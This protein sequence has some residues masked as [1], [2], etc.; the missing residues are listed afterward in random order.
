M[1]NILTVFS[2]PIV[3]T[4][5]EKNT[6]DLKK[7]TIF[8][9]NDYQEY[10]DKSN[11]RVL[12]KYPNVK[13]IL[14]EEYK[15]FAREKL[16]YTEEFNIS[17]SWITQIETGGLCQKHCHKNSFYSGVYYF[18]EYEKDEGGKLEFE[19]PLKNFSDFFLLPKEWNLLNSTMLEITPVKNLLILFPSYLNHRVLPYYGKTVRKS[20]AFNI[21][22]VGG[23][24][25]G[26]ST[27]D[28]SWFKPKSWFN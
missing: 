20:L 25:Q 2:S 14:L 22:P 9:T 16:H 4:I 17:T 28:T 6:N 1:E 10:E 8:A 7:E 23:Y 3:T 15:K 12:E 26:D 19:S 24:G 21:V 11:F 5:I 18:D 13:K 27:Y